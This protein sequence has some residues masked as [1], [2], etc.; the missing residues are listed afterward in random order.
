M[1]YLKSFRWPKNIHAYVFGEH[2]D[3][4]FIPWTGVYVSG[5]HVDEYVNVA[6]RMGKDIKPIDK[7]EMIEYVRKSGGIVI[8]KKGATFYAVSRIGMSALQDLTGIF[9][10][11]CDGIFHDAWRVWRGRRL[12]KYTDRWLDRRVSAVRFPCE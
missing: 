6:Q 8:A 5:I 12:L 10:D 9:R 2:G 7:D 3:T 1:D 11:R 4:S